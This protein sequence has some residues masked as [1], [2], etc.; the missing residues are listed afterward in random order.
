MKYH[1]E[2]FGLQVSCSFKLGHYPPAPSPGAPDVV[3]IK[4]KL[5][6]PVDGLDQTVYKPY[7]VYNQDFYY[8]EISGIARFLIQ[9][10]DTVYLEKM[11]GAKWNDVFAFLFDT[12]FTVL[13]MKNEIFVFHASAVAF[14]RK[15]LLFCAGGGLGKSTLAASLAANRGAR[16]IEDDRCLLEFN[17]RSGNFQVRNQFPFIELWKPQHGFASRIKGVDKGYA[18]RTAIAK[19]RFPIHAHVPARAV[20]L[21]KIV[22]VNMNQMEDKIE[23]D[24]ITGIEKVRVVKNYTHL[25]HMLKPLGKST[26]HFKH[27]SQVVQGVEVHRVRKSRST[28]LPK[29]IKFIEDEIIA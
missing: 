25:D 26:A 9:G 23:Y 11:P 8:L 15:A 27:I 13:L 4:K 28:K 24:Q 21:D 17:K 16:I 22:L 14:G 19:K 20:R 7:S 5:A 3:L 1:Y 2:V 10:K 18:I 6:R 12:I 29:F